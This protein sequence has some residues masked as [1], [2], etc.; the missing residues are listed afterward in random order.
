MKP[1][2]LLAIALIINSCK[3][4][5][6]GSAPITVSNTSESSNTQNL[7]P[8]DGVCSIKTHKNS[9]LTLKVDTTDRY[10]PVIEQGD[11][12]VVEFTFKKK[13]PNGTADGDY[14]ETIHFQISEINEDLQ[15]KNEELNQVHLL[16][17]KH[18][19]C[20]GEA[21][22]YKVNSGILK[23]SRVKDEIT[24]DLEFMLNEVSHKIINVTETITI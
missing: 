12:I 18:C 22:Y 15:I 23:L 13:G 16:F 11:H 10:Y 21:G 6:L 5:S 9:K 1:Y 14:S 24:I 19:F 17:G 7:C 20:K 4:S 3:A 8:E 2:F